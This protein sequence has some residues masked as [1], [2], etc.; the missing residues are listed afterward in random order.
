MQIAPVDIEDYEIDLL[1]AVL[2]DCHSYDF[3]NYARASLKRRV[4]RVLDRCE[5]KRI[6]ELIP[7]V[8]HEPGFCQMVVE[9]LT[10]QV[11]EMFRDPTVFAY[12]REAVIP[13]LKTWPFVKIWVAGCS[14]G[15]EVYSLAIL[16]KEADLYDR[17]RIFATDINKRALS[18]AQEGI[19]PIDAIREYGKSY[20]RAGGRGDIRDYFTELYEFGRIDQSLKKN[21]VFS[22]HN[23]AVDNVFSEVHLVLCR[24]VMIYFDRTLQD[25]VFSL[26]HESLVTGGILCIGSRETLQFSSL[27]GEFDVNSRDAC[28][29]RKL[30][31]AEVVA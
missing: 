29:Y 8:I 2:C 24:N 20:T 3:R 9:E 5:C 11:T 27:A 4:L 12:L 13:L 6:S 15:E 26:F 19:Y 21:I 25:R 30:P 23:L 16:L 22:R 31:R 7:R 14:S 17:V 18:E 28:V 10:V 1:V